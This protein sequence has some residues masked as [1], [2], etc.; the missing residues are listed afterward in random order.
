MS[1]ICSIFATLARDHLK[2]SLL[3]VHVVQKIGDF[4]RGSAI[5]LGRFPTHINHFRLFVTVFCRVMVDFLGLGEL[6]LVDILLL[7]QGSVLGVRIFYLAAG[8][9]GDLL[10]EVR[11]RAFSLPVV[12]SCGLMGSL[13]IIMFL[14]LTLL[15]SASLS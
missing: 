6:V 11:S 9:E 14:H 15:F 10:Y 13:S 5:L 3:F 2:V 8:L 4:G 1:L 12:R 7:N